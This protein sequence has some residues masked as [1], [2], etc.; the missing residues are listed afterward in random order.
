[1][2]KNRLEKFIRLFLYFSILSIGVFYI[3]KSMKNEIQLYMTPSEL[4]Q[5][6]G[7]NHI[8]LGGLVLQHSTK[9]TK[10]GVSFIVTDLKNQVKVYYQGLLPALFKENKGVVVIGDW[11]KKYV[12]ATKVLA[13]HDENYMPPKVRRNS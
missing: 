5:Y 1:M 7:N 6:S 13:K 9:H 11:N 4:V 2:P 10:N 3:L 8:Q 12:L